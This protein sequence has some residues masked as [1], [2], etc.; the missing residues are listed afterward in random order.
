VLVQ[1][2]KTTKPLKENIIM[3]TSKNCSE[4]EI[5]ASVAEGAPRNGAYMFADQEK[6][7]KV[8]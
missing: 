7:E 2:K 8:F 3:K 6:G 5:R 1:K 4:R